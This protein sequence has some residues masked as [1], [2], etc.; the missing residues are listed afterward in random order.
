MERIR[1]VGDDLT[2]LSEQSGDQAEHAAHSRFRWINGA[3]QATI[4]VC[5]GVPTDQLGRPRA[6]LTFAS[7]WSG[8]GGVAG[9][10]LAALFLGC[11]M[12]SE[13]YDPLRLSAAAAVQTLDL[14]V[15]DDVR[16]RVIPML[17][18]LPAGTK[19]AAVVLFSHG[20]G[21]SR[22]GSSYLGEHWA[23]RGY[24]AVF[25]QHPGSDESV[26]RDEPPANVLA[27]LSRAATGEN[28]LLRVQDVAA[29]LDQL[30]RWNEETGHALSGRLDLERV[31]MAGHSF[32]AMT[33][34][35]VSGQSF[36]AAPNLKPHPQIRAAVIM[37]PSAPA[38][39]D[40]ATAFSSVAMPWMLMTGTR[41]VAPIGADLAARFEVYP[42]LPDSIDK[43]EL[44]LY[45]GQHYAFTDRALVGSDTARDPNHHRVILALSTAFWDAYLLQDRGALAWL[46]GAGPRSVLAKDDGWR[47]FAGSAP[48]N[49]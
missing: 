47:F 15:R 18:Y 32:G 1:T 26:W 4:V 34:Q 29:V 5:A 43:Y 8:P 46:Q 45:E 21:G 42:Y 27:A 16:Q 39:G 37:S 38:Q 49:K 28:L 36:P 11:F 10:A 30:A 22:A 41:D 40:A 3:P 25:L 7:P 13:S 35:A 17:V 2:K 14:V 9:L 44:V 48:D 33:T 12:K 31:G 24:V 6:S 20:L 19:P 23:A